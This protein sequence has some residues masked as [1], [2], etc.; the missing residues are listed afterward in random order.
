MYIWEGSRAGISYVPEI[1][2]F[3][4]QTGNDH[5]VPL[6]Q[7]VFSLGT[8]G[9]PVG[10]ILTAKLMGVV[11]EQRSTTRTQSLYGLAAA[12]VLVVFHTVRGLRA[13]AV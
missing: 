13:A 10:V 3:W 6:L 9:G 11:D 1:L 8:F 4:C 7:M 5:N 12:A 2:T